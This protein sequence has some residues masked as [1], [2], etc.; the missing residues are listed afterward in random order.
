MDAT[1]QRVGLGGSDLDGEPEV[2]ASSG[3]IRHNIADS[4]PSPSCRQPLP[5]FDWESR[6][7]F[8][9]VSRPADAGPTADRR[10]GAVARDLRMRMS[11]MAPVVRQVAIPKGLEASTSMRVETSLSATAT[12]TI[13]S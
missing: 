9:E 7:R 12:S 1:G 2:L 6:R 4:E 11:R 8:V 10:H 5:L 13:L 3:H